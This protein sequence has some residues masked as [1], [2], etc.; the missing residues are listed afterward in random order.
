MF[1]ISWQRNR[2]L[3]KEFRAEL[4]KPI[5]CTAHMDKLTN[6]MFV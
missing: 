2:S 3:S 1:S 6:L 5:S 4:I